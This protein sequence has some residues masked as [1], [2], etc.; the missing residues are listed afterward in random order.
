MTTAEISRPETSRPT[1]EPSPR[2]RAQRRLRAFREWWPAAPAVLLYALGAVI[3]LGFFV[4]YSFWKLDFFE[5]VP[6]WN[7]DNYTNILTDPVFRKLLV[8]TLVIAFVSAVATTIIATALA[9][10]ARFTFA[11]WQHLILFG[12]LLALFS[13]YL[14]RIFAWQTMLGGKGF[15]NSILMSLHIV[16]QPVEALLYTRLT[17]IIVLTN[18]LIPLAFLPCNAAFSNIRDAEVAAAR[19]L[20][21][22]AFTAYRRVILPLAWPGIFAAFSLSFIVAAGDYLTG[23]LVGGKTG[24]MVGEAIGSTFL[25]QFDWPTGSA[26]A[27][28]EFC[29]VI[30]VVG[31]FGLVARK[32]VR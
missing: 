25:T 29:I 4:I 10:L 2:P 8:N 12:V 27:V 26:M 6:Q 1:E 19:D 13:G 14:V 15:L 23:T 28:I 22:S 18:F 20:G 32:V 11:K 30:M 7:L 9:S 24:K 5:I 17:A 3:P 21:A 16:D 31:V